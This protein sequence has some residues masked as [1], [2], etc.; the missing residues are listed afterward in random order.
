VFIVLGNVIQQWPARRS[1]ALAAH[2]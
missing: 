2:E 1:R